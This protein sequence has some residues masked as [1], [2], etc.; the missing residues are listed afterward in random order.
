MN[1]CATVQN[2]KF[3]IVGVVNNFKGKGVEGGCSVFK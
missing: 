3:I 2:N 1:F